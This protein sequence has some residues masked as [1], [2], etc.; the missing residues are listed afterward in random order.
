M[1]DKDLYWL[2][3]WLEGEGS[4]L[5]G[6]PSMPN[7]CAINGASTD[8]DIIEKLSTLLKVK[9]HKQKRRKSDL[10]HYK[11]VYS[12][13]LSGQL[14]YDLMA[15]LRPLMGIR[16]QEQIDKAMSG[17]KV[18]RVKLTKHKLDKIKELI[19]TGLSLRKIAAEVDVDKSTVG[20]IKN[21][22]YTHDNI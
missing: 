18:K 10:P 16:R 20:H 11:T 22:K 21:G 4:F 19:S 7:M 9:C 13:R 5:H 6:C 17:Y 1:E 2:A 8:K 3:G 15:K 14:A 12:I